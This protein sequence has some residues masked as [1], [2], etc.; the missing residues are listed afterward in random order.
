MEKKQ[1]FFSAV[2]RGLSPARSR[3]RSQSP[4]RS[5]SPM[6]TL[7]FRRWKGSFRTQQQLNGL[8]DPPVPRSCSLEPLM[9]G[10]DPG[11]AGDG[12]DPRR[13]RNWFLL[14]RTPSVSGSGHRRSD[15][16]LLLGVMGA[17]LAPIHV[18]YGEPLPHLS[19]KDTPIVRALLIFFFFFSWL[20]VTCL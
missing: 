13:E 15:L 9:E 18:S 2:T 11:E 7:L 19:I 4:V 6:T 12:G 5:P 20:L 14:S 17:P 1:G 16:R 3:S 8:L 10:L